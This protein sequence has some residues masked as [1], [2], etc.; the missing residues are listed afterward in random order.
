M[1]RTLRRFILLRV[2]SGIG[3]CD[4]GDGDG[5]S[6][7]SGDVIVMAMLVV[8]LGGSGGG[9]GGDGDCGG[10]DNGAVAVTGADNGDGYGDGGERLRW[11]RLTSSVW[12]A[13][14]LSVMGVGVRF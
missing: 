13:R 9:G 12:L 5:V 14:R 8:M 4:V 6:G 2:A 10:D 3:N 1:T 7:G 11:R